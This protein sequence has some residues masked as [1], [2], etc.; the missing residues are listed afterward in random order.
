[1]V[2]KH[3]YIIIVLLYQQIN[4]IYIDTKLSDNKN[5]DI[6]FIEVVTIKTHL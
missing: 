3:N 1:M 4:W 5:T 2:E 6:S